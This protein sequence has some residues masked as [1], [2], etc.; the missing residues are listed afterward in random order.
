MIASFDQ[1][2]IVCALQCEGNKQDRAQ[3]HG[4]ALGAAGSWTM[5][6]LSLQD[7]KG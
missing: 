2:K 1:L 7:L 5:R 6:P 4:C 3:M